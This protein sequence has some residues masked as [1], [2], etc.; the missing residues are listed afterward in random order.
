M[1]FTYIITIILILGTSCS[2]ETPELTKDFNIIAENGTVI[3]TQAQLE[4]WTAEVVQEKF[5]NVNF[6]LV[7]VTT[8]YKNSSYTSVID[9]SV[10]SETSNFVIANYNNSK[11]QS[12]VDPCDKIRFTCSDNSCCHVMTE[13]G[14]GIFKC[15]CG[16][17]ESGTTCS[18]TIECMDQQ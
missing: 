11:S 6:K 13:V 10:G 8:S 2:T 18:M 17:S 1:K 12:R 5:G 14:S 15:A 7:D 16:N 9:Y 3:A 4:Q